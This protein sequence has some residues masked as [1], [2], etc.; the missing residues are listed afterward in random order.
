MKTHPAIDNSFE[1][2]E[3]AMRCADCMG[4]EIQAYLEYAA[5]KFQKNP[6]GAS[7][8][9]TWGFADL[10]RQFHG[11][12]TMLERTAA[13]YT[14]MTAESRTAARDC[15]ERIQGILLAM[16]LKGF[17]TT[18]LAWAMLG[19]L[20]NINTQTT[21]ARIRNPKRAQRE[22]DKF[23]ENLIIAMNK[24]RRTVVN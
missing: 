1:A 11:D 15:K 3:D 7:W 20:S 17:S 16:R 13:T 10:L 4:P 23:T 14:E 6:D 19:A 2:Q 9:L 24:A 21:H 18:A 5:S 22:A 8:A 12:L